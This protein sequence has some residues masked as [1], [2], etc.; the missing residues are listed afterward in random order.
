MDAHA[1]TH[2][3][4]TRARTH[5]QRPRSNAPKPRNTTNLLL[6]HKGF[7]HSLGWNQFC[8]EVSCNWAKLLFSTFTT[9]LWSTVNIMITAN[10]GPQILCFS[11]IWYVHL[12]GS[13]IS[14]N[15]ITYLIIWILDNGFTQVFFLFLFIVL[16]Y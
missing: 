5:T 8:W 3:K 9:I 13:V 15:F 11:W 12:V 4:H 14:C 16:A 1:H 7:Q 10:Y 2:T 6:S